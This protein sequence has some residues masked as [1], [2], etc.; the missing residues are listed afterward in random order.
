MPE[1]DAL[2]LMRQR[3]DCS[4][5]GLRLWGNRHLDHD[6]Q[7]GEA[8]GFAHERCNMEKQQQNH[9]VVLFHNLRNFDGHLFITR[10]MSHDTEVRVIAKNME[11]YSAIFTSKLRFIDTMQHLSSGLA[12]LVKNLHPKPPPEDPNEIPVAFRIVEE[13][14]TETYGASSTKTKMGLK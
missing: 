13:F 2:E 14:I 1:P 11:S 10:L 8:L 6:H 7:T 5:C 4:I 12:R 3:R 9:L